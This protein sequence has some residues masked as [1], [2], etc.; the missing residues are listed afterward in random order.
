MLSAHLFRLQVTWQTGIAAC[1][2]V[3]LVWRGMTPNTA[4]AWTPEE[5]DLM[6]SLYPKSPQVEVMQALP[7][8]AWDRIRDRA[9]V[10]GLR[11]ATSHAGPHPFN[12]YH[13]TMRYDDLEAAA[14]L[15][16]DP[17]QQDCLRELV[18]VL[19]QQ[20]VSGGFRRIG[21]FRSIA[22]ATCVTLNPRP[23]RPRSMLARSH[24]DRT[25]Q[26]D[27]FAVEHRILDDMLR[28][29]GVLLRA[30]QP[31]RERHL[32]AQRDTCRLRQTCQQRRIEEA[33]R[34]TDD[35]NTIA[36]QL[37]GGGQRQPYNAALGRRIGRLPDL[38]LERGD[39]GGIDDDTTL[40]LAVRLILSH[41][42]GGQSQRIERADEVH[43]YDF[44]ELTQIMRPML[45]DHFV[46]DADTRT[47]DQDAD[48]A[49]PAGCRRDRMLHRTGVGHI[50]FD[51]LRMVPKLG[52]QRLTSIFVQIRDDDGRAVGH[53][54][55]YGGGAEPGCATCDEGTG[56]RYLHGEIHSSRENTARRPRDMRGGLT[57]QRDTL[58]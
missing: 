3:A 41:R 18:N 24:A 26:S 13:R 11:R 17:A 23:Q 14:R 36:C 21:G 38:P 55:A 53:E 29:R 5:D 58:P 44:V 32:L 16:D 12:V 22:S 20:T 49:T 33:R 1:P 6:W 42:G 52:C 46:G 10:L 28:Q 40:T 51:E 2:D 54:T 47:A 30:P 31:R 9:Q 56:S 4:G 25:V 35:A 45:A 34:D 8:R 39:G 43:L 57:R 48:T 7:C 19:A 50:R 15:V 27:C 37:A